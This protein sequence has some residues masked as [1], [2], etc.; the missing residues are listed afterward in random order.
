VR[1]CFFERR[2]AS[3]AFGINVN[4]LSVLGSFRKLINAILQ[5]LDPVAH[6]DVLPEVFPELVNAF[7]SRHR[8]LI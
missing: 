5:N 7:D 1:Y 4:P 8:H 6:P 3:G 2:F